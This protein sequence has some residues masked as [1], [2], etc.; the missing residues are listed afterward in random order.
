MMVVL[1]E[2]LLGQAS[3]TMQSP[4]PRLPPKPITITGAPH[5]FSAA[6]GLLVACCM[7]PWPFIL[8]W[9]QVS[10]RPRKTLSLW[11]PSIESRQPIKR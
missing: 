1:S 5:V 8:D 10:Q 6:R 2:L 7:H 9:A 3:I 4:A 11:N